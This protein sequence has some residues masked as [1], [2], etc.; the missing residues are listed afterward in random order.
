MPRKFG[1]FTLPYVS[2]VLSYM[3]NG[4]KLQFRPDLSENQLGALLAW[5]PR[6]EAPALAAEVRERLEAPPW[7]D[8]LDLTERLDPVGDGA[9]ITMDPAVGNCDEFRMDCRNVP[10]S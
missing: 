9:R 4:S 10:Y 6:L 7:E 2:L 1:L 3:G 5:L 8:A